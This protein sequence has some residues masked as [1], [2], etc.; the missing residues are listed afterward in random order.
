MSDLERDMRACASGYDGTGHIA[1]KYLMRG[2][3]RIAELELAIELAAHALE[4]SY[5][6]LPKD[7]YPGPPT[8]IINNLRHVL[9][10]R[11]GS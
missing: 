2:A 10:M 6:D 7:K 11:S 5:G 4:N 3:D 1:Q 9:A 8:A